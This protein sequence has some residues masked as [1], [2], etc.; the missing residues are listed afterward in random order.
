MGPVQISVTDT[1]YAS[2]SIGMLVNTDPV[3]THAAD[4]FCAGTGAVTC[5]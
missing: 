3:A 2:G 5:P 1:T 4:N